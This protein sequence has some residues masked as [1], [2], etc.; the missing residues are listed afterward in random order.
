MKEYEN[1]LFLDKIKLSAVILDKEGQLNGKVSEYLT[2]RRNGYIHDKHL[3]DSEK[4]PSCWSLIYE[5]YMFL[6][7]NKIEELK[8]KFE[9]ECDTM[10][11]SM[12]KYEEEDSL[13]HVELISS[14]DA[15]AK[16]I[17][18]SGYH[19]DKRQSDEEDGWDKIG[20]E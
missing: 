12:T 20:F 7:H 18:K 8:G 11:S 1:S 2:S 4:F 16:L 19:D 9:D 5:L 14:Y 10:V 3:K 17:T 15:I 6:K 13:T